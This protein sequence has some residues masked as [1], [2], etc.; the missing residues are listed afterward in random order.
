M[1][2]PRRGHPGELLGRQRDNKGTAHLAYA[3]FPATN[4]LPTECGDI[5]YIN[6][7]PPYS[8]WTAPITLNDDGPGHAQGFP[9]V[10]VGR[11]GTVYVAWEDH[12][13]DASNLYY[14]IYAVQKA[15]QDTAFSANVRV[16]DVS[17][18]IYHDSNSDLMGQHI[19]MAL[20]GTSPFL[21]WTDRRNLGASATVNS[22]NRDISGSHVF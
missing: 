12:R 9:T 11:N 21:V 5:Q 14:D 15:R 1:V 4:I 13:A 2:L 19:G 16:T 7:D 3:K 20:T 18:L 22:Y 6:S 17:S 8:A 10:A